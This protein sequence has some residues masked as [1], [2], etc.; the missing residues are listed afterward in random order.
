MLM[1]VGITLYKCQCKF[2]SS[3]IKVL[4]KYHIALELYYELAKPF[5]FKKK[6]NLKN[7]TTTK[8]AVAVFLWV[9]VVLFSPKAPVLCIVLTGEGRK[10]SGAGEQSLLVIVESG[11]AK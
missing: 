4:I 8:K 5:R 11:I 3:V 1:A 10:D 2:I 9:L 6:G 7:I